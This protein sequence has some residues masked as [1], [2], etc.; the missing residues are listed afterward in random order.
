MARLVRS[1]LALAAL[2]ALSAAACSFSPA[3][4]AGPPGTDG[5]PS[6]DGRATD[7]SLTSADAAVDAAPRCDPSYTLTFGTSHYLVLAAVD[8]P[9][10]ASMCTASRGHLVKIEAADEDAFL[11]AALPPASFAWT[12]LSDETFADGA[13]HWADGTALG[14][15]APFPGG[16]TPLSATKNC[17]DVGTDGTW[18]AFYCDFPQTAICEC[19]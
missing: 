13:Y 14:A 16:T 15:Y 17:V 10:A 6:T 4:T 7:A 12:G 9:T 18:H 8:Q 11:A 1:S 3:S 2:A 5:G 19:D